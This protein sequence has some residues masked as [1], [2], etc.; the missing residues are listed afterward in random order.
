MERNLE[1]ADRIVRLIVA[2]LIMALYMGGRIIG[3][4]ADV[5]LV[6]SIVMI[7]IYL[8]E[9]VLRKPSRLR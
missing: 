4:S 5:L 6:F 9:T 1:T 8:I 2:I 3:P 7:A